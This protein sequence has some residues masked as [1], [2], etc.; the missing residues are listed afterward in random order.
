MQSLVLSLFPGIDLFGR[1]FEAEGFCVVRGPD[2]IYGSD[3][4]LF[5]PVPGRFDGVIGGPPC[6]DFS[7]AQRGEPTGYGVEM[8]EEFRRCVVAAAPLWWLM[9]NVSGVPDMRIDGYSHQRIDINASECGLQQNRLRHFQFGHR[10][11]L[12]LTVQRQPARADVEPCC[13]ASE[14][15]QLG[16]RDWLRFCQLQGLHDGIEL[17]SFTLS[18]R[19]RAVGN[20]VPVDM[21]RMLARGV[22]SLRSPEDVRVCECGCG[23]EV[24][25]RARLATMA[26]RQ[27]VS[28]R[29]RAVTDPGALAIDQSL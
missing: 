15:S 16:R 9:E 29:R 21:A 26:C 11:G 23:R 8:L 19:Y 17:P 4:R 14:G 20:G 12:I 27:R 1:G 24:E 22:L 6:P 2:I 3:V 7:R 13:T 28:R 5:H 25:G 10:D 18:A